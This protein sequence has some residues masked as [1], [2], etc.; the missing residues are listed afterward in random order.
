MKKGSSNLISEQMLLLVCVSIVCLLL[1]YGIIKK[2]HT[3]YE[4]T[5]KSYAYQ[6]EVTVSQEKENTKDKIAPIAKSL[7]SGV[8]LISKFTINQYDLNQV[9]K[10]SNTIELENLSIEEKI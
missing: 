5:L 8:K 3:T 6:D 7:C 4:I 10:K 9:E 1:G 2:E